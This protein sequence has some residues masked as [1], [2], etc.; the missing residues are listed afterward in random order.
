MK[1]IKSIDNFRAI[2]MIVMIWIHLRLWWLT[3]EYQ[4]FVLLTIPFTDRV[5]AS[6]FLIIAGASSA[7]FTRGR[8]EKAKKIENYDIAKVKKEFYLRAFLIFIIALGYN[9]FVAIMFMNPLLIWKWFLLLTTSISLM[10]IW[11]L[12]KFSKLFRISLAFIIWILN[13]YIISFLSQFQGQIDVFGVFYYIL[14]HSLDQDP[15]LFAFSFF[16]LGSVFGDFIS[17]VNKITIEKKR[18]IALRNR[19][20]LPALISGT[21]LIIIGLIYEIPNYN[22]NVNF[23]WIAYPLGFNLILLSIL[24]I[25][26]EFNILSFKTKF[27]FLHYFS[28]YSLTIFFGHNILYFLFYKQLSFFYAW[29]IIPSIIFLC[30]LIMHFIH[31]SRWR[32][33]FSIKLVLGEITKM[34]LN[35]NKK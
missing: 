12:L 28:Y 11:P 31:K 16:L 21:I 15:I 25:I 19:I 29:L 8:I 4:W 17:D 10:I 23:I 6:A 20:L 24:I 3:D 27:R 1:R 22:N 26:E 2:T 34:I 9:S 30:G 5:F 18:L 32:Q 33:D 14:Y 35:R 13:Y 7:L